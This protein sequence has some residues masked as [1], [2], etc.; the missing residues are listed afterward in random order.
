MNTKVIL[1]SCK[2]FIKTI[3]CVVPYILLLVIINYLL[4]NNI[5]INNAESPLVYF[6]NI[7]NVCFFLFSFYIFISYEFFRK[8]KEIFIDETL[9]SYGLRSKLVPA[10]QMIVLMLC[11]LFSSINIAIYSFIGGSYNDFPKSFLNDIIKMNILDIVLLSVTANFIGLLIAKLKNRLWGYSVLAIVLTCVSPALNELLYQLN[12]SNI[13]LYKIRDLLNFL[14][15]D[16]NTMSDKLYGLPLENYRFAIM[17]TWILSVT[18]VFAFI[19]LKKKETIRKVICGM[20]SLGLILSLFIYFDR[21]SIL[22]STSHPDAS[23][24]NVAKFYNQN[25]QKYETADF[26]VDTYDITLK[27]DKKLT[28]TVNMK[29]TPHQTKQKGYK[30][31]LY[32]NYKI[33]KIYDEVG[34]SLSFTRD[35]D[36]FEVLKPSSAD[37]SNIIVEYSGFSEAFYS[38]EHAVFLPGFFAY[39]PQVGYNVVFS[40]KEYKYVSTECTASKFNVKINSDLELVSNLQVNGNNIEG[41][42]KHLTLVGGFYSEEKINGTNVIMYPLDKNLSSSLSQVLSTEY[43]QRLER[44]KNLIGE[45][46]DV[47]LIGK[48]II[49]IP[50]SLSFNTLLKGI[51]IY[52]DSI[53]INSYSIEDNEYKVFDAYLPNSIEK[54][55]LKQSF[56]NTIYRAVNEKELFLFSEIGATSKS[57]QVSDTLTTKIIE[58]GV[59]YVAPIVYE[60]LKDE[61]NTQD[62][63]EF[64]NNIK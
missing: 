48:K 17:L 11:V 27:I 2:L 24:E 50:F 22:L 38:N 12:Y 31:T 30:F 25:N 46:N 39:Y 29:I 36:Y 40:K 53:I 51:Y 32:H 18:G 8:T 47:S 19:W 57:A 55:N 9:D 3:S 6:G 15:P 41:V 7:R 5:N 59:E 14:T 28:A 16:L 26:E 37:I 60:Y 61:N 13:P 42:A 10:S 4:V 54:Q 34:N 49:N 1:N 64:L 45:T 58:L 56:S 23:T 21:G 43:K 44:A 63:L 20:L 62:E 52:D 33:E 35:G